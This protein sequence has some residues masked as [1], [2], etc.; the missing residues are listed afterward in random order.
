MH[1]CQ[2]IYNVG[3]DNC[4]VIMGRLGT[5]DQERLLM[6]AGSKKEQQQYFEDDFILIQKFIFYSTFLVIL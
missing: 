4:V 5:R 3:W 1:S 2:G 6:I